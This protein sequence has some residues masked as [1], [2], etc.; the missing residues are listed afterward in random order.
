VWAGVL[1]QLL[2]S[3]LFL[4]T[5]SFAQIGCGFQPDAAW[6]NRVA[7]FK[8][9]DTLRVLAIWTV[10]NNPPVDTANKKLPFFWRQMW[11]SNQLISVPR[12]YAENSDRKYILNVDPLG[13]PDS[14]CFSPVLNPVGFTGG[15]NFTREVLFLA[16]PYVNFANY[17]RD[18]DKFIEDGIGSG[19]T[20]GNL[21]F[22]KCLTNGGGIL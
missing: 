10:A 9:T 21:R 17:D 14:F 13:A 2:I 8:E 22:F 11:D 5:P 18:G 20:I 15:R 3:F 4:Y 6:Q 1:V 7:A 12:F 19:E 16:D